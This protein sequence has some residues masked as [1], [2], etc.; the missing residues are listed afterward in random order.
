[1]IARFL[2]HN[3]RVLALVV[4]SIVVAGL[5]SFQLIPRLEDP[6]LGKRV[7]VVTTAWPGADAS[8][9][10][11]LLTEVVEQSIA[12]IPEIK[13]VKSNTR[14]G[15]SNVVVE[16]R[17]EV[18]DPDPVWSDVREAVD[19]NRTKLPKL[20]GQPVQPALEV[21]PL[22]AYAAI[23]AVKQKGNV[24]SPKAIRRI[25]RSLRSRILLLDGTEKAD[26]FGVGEDAFEVT[27]DTQ[28]LARLST[29][30]PGIAS[31]IKQSIQQIPG[32]RIPSLGSELAIDPNVQ[33]GVGK[34]EGLR[35]QPN[36][37]SPTVQLSDVA[38]IQRTVSKPLTELAIID[39]KRSMV[40]AA[41]V[42]DN[43]RIDHW[44]NSLNR[45]LED[46]ESVH[47]NSVSIETIFSQADHVDQRLSVLWLNLG[48]ATAAVA[49]V[50]FLLMGVRSALIVSAAL[51]LSALLVVSGMRVMS[52][53]IHQ[54]SVTGLI[55]ALGLLID[56]AIVM[57]EE[58]SKRIRNGLGVTESISDAVRHLAVP[59]LGSTITTALAFLPIATLPGPAGEFVGTIAV[60]VILAIVSSFVLSMTA[61]PALFGLLSRNRDSVQE[62]IS[63]TSDS[64]LH[65]SILRFVLT[66][67]WLAIVP[68]LLIL[69]A[70]YFCGRE[71][72]IQFFPASDRQQIQIEI[73]AAAA[74]NVESL[75]KSVNSVAKLVESDRDVQ[76]QHWFL[77]R[78]AP[79]FFYNVVPR[80]KG[81]PFYAQG[82][83]DLDS[84]VDPESLVRRLQEVLDNEILDCRCLVRQ[85]QQGPPFDAPVELRISGPD[86]EVLQVLGADLRLMLAGLPGVISTRSDL[87]DSKAGLS[88]KFDAKAIGTQTDTQTRVSQLL[89]ASL[90]GAN[91]GSMLVD[92]GDLPIKVRLSLPKKGALELVK[93]LPLISPRPARP[94]SAQSQPPAQPVATTI[95]HVADFQLK[96]EIG[97]IIR[98]DGQRTNEVKAYIDAGVLP[99][100]V[101]E[102][103][104]QTLSDSD[105][106]L[107]NGYALDYG[108]ETEQRS[109]AIDLLI[110]NSI[111]L[112]AL[113]LLTLVASFRSFR[114][115]GIVAVVGL[116]AA[117]L[118]P[119]SLYVF[120]FPFGFMAI[121]GTMG[122]VGIAINDSIVVLAAIRGDQLA[123]QGDINSIATVV[124][125][126]T[127]HILATTLTTILG[128]TPLVISSGRFWPPL[129]ITIAGGVGGATL[130]ALWFVPA[131]YC[132]VTKKGDPASA[133]L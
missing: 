121:L 50:V 20:G 98:V 79:T 21:F 52:I 83:L 131:C 80:R 32:G 96:S 127:R 132:I 17:D 2:Y 29:S 8:Q 114:C 105:F 100:R 94:P 118:A 54:M 38:T 126:C 65:H 81:T 12:S 18:G 120:G 57:V 113:M 61:I 74:A 24:A 70:G 56:N 37:S 28:T 6:V 75:E 86:L 133:T 122:L 82:M 14:A 93:A 4:L 46:F 39:G 40:V 85:L 41:L 31:Q 78:S 110:A 87:Q 108:G 106:Q 23:L 49:L 19:L 69:M 55:V 42:D 44:A 109:H 95:S 72:P 58:I 102:S 129:A 34:L 25:A 13:S 63:E 92:D 89:Y 77:G 128:F 51:P 7:G 76:R 10:E 45:E 84:D 101:I 123:R 62:P 91:A 103:F 5:T 60:S 15:I 116:L 117:C 115:A 112:F 11:S 67:P 90:E 99:S 130:L 43:M 27:F 104:E 119:V 97:G 16:L 68:T 53:P 111:F 73:E 9:V 66:R 88:L 30:I 64:G 1:M 35:I 59:L 26:L 36:P 33:G 3:P 47:G 107:P 125:G 124:H 71:L 48:L 22:K